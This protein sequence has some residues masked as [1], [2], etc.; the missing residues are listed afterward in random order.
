[1]KHDD[2]LW[3]QLLRAVDHWLDGDL[4]DDEEQASEDPALL[5]H[6]M[7]TAPLVIGF[8]IIVRSAVS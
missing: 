5:H 3:N 8:L 4:D 2:S 6:L 7:F 1:M